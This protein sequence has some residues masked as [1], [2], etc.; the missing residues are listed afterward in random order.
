MCL[1]W[2]CIINMNI[3]CQPVVKRKRG[4][5]AKLNSDGTKKSVVKQVDPS[6]PKRGRGR[7]RKVAAE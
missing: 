1:R 7:P 4:R 2:T 3:S 5:P 6:A